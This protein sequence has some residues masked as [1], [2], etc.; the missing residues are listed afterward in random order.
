MLAF[1]AVG[2]FVLVSVKGAEVCYKRIG[3]FSDVKPWSGTIERPIVILPWAPEAI[4]TRFLLYT[5]NNQNSYQSLSAI[6]PSTISSSN[7]RTTRKTRFVIH[8]FLDSGESKWLS[9]ICR[10]LLQMEDVNCIAVDWRNGSHAQYPQAVNNIRVV[11]AEVAYFVKILLRNFGYSPSNVHLIGHSLGAHAAGEAGKRQ[12]G[13]SRITGLDPA[14]PYFQDTPK[15]VHLDL[16]DGVL[17]D[18]LHTDA[19]PWNPDLGLE[20]SQIIGHLDFFPNGGIQMPGCLK[21]TEILKVSIEDVFNGVA[22]FGSC[23][24]M[25][26]IIYYTES[27]TNSSIFTSYPCSSYA[28]YQAGSCRSCPRAGCPKMGHYADQYRGVTASSQV[29]YLNTP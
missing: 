12:I 29:F 20:I 1:L 28:T 7:F 18:V 2:F 25:R 13:I 10:R 5:R 15:E 11:G 17:V 14:K 9:N 21:N 3:C 26:A 24:H 23:N 4:N 27:I 19:G 22:S 16:F 8:G 6:N